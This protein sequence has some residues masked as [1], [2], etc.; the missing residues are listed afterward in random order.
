[1]RKSLLQLVLLWGLAQT[2]FGQTTPPE[3]DVRLPP[4]FDRVLRAYEAAWKKHDAHGLAEL[5]AADG[6]VLAPGHPPVRGRA[7]IERA[8]ADAGGPL[9]LR[10]IAFASENNVAYIIGAF[11]RHKGE[12]DIGKFT[13]T[14]KRDGKSRWLIVSDMDN[15]NRLPDNLETR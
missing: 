8:Y 13:L 11:A 2:P 7:A 10:G 3:P 5:F 4:E 15:S 6:F 1:M 9:A 12:P 14:L